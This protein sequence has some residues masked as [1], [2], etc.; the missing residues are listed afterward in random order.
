MPSVALFK[1]RT[2]GESCFPPTAYVETLI[3]SVFI[4]DDNPI[5][6]GTVAIPHSCG[7]TTHFNRYITSASPTVF[8][9]GIAIARIGDPISCGDCVAKGSG[10]VFAD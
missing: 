6:L 1:G 8:G 3:R 4:N 5:H 7:N 2:A 9:D 10:N